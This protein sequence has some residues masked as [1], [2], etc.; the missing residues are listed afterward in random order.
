[1]LNYDM[2]SETVLVRARRTGDAMTLSGGRRSLKRL[3]IDRK[4]PQEQRSRIPVL[5]MGE[6]VLAV[7][8][9]GADRT[10]LPRAGSR[11]LVIEFVQPQQCKEKEEY[12]RYDAGH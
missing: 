5:S 4:I 3:M 7:Y 9:V 1:L 12:R 8:G 11:I 6:Q 10:F 2:I